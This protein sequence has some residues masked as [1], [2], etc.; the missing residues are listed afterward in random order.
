MI[1]IYI[2]FKDK[3]K[4]IL[5]WCFKITYLELESQAKNDFYSLLVIAIETTKFL[6]SY[7]WEFFKAFPLIRNSIFVIADVNRFPKLNVLFQRQLISANF[8]IRNL[9]ESFFIMNHPQI[10]LWKFLNTLKKLLI[11]IEDFSF[12]FIQTLL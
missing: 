10:V 3:N 9:F 1:F 7:L 2:I 4:P 5:S 8:N 12:L 11:K 6:S